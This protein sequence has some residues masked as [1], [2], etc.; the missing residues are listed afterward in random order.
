MGRIHGRAV[1]VALMAALWMMIFPSTALAH[2]HLKSSAPATGAHLAQVPAALRLD[3]SE[4]PELAFTWVRLHMSDGREIPLTALVYAPDSHRSVI[5]TVAGA[6]NAGTYLVTWQMAGDDGHPVRGQ[7][8]FVIAPGAMGVG[9]A[10]KP[11][12]GTATV[13]GLEA[14]ESQASMPA[15]HHNP[16][17]MPE[18]NGFGAESLLYVLVRWL[19]FV[20]LLVVVG[21][22]TF[23]VFVLGRLRRGQ[24]LDGERTEGAFIG[25]ARE[26][27]ARQGEVAAVA[28]GVTL[29]CRLLAQ[30][31]AM[32]GAENALNVVLAWQMV[33]K[34]VWGW[35]WMLQLFGVLL[36]FAG[37][38][39]TRG[40]S[41]A[42]ESG[43]AS[44]DTHNGRA[45]WWKLAALGA[46]GCA[47]SPAISGHAS[48]TPRW[49]ALAILADALHVLGASSWLGTLAVLLMAGLTAARHEAP[50]ARGQFVRS[51]VNA[52]SP[53]ALTSAGVA[54][55]TGAFAAWLHVGTIP[56]LWGT[57]YGIT[58]LVKLV[59]LSVVALTGFYNWRFVRRR[60]GTDAAMTTLRRSA[61]VETAVA[62]IV[63]LVTAILVASPTSMDATM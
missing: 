43:I 40:A 8:D 59:V 31:Y 3:F 49:R 45:V 12:G 9:V 11:S 54:L 35:G 41:E 29:A 52:Y 5:A 61:S 1:L 22:V 47:L 57:R 44:H 18:G 32:H 19:E 58:L 36:A 34:T 37:F 39:G 38:H 15:M 26:R 6:M 17:S 30:S 27:A 60:L 16:V 25:A 14:G 55:V 20:A 13:R 42:K 63:L 33:R 28:L 2:G 62:V 4:T 50:L 10:P 7:F 51:L 56:N 23:R 24:G 21:A 46:I 53:V 48:S